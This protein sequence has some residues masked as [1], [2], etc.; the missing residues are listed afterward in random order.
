MFHLTHERPIRT[1][2]RLSAA[3][4]AGCGL[5]LALAACSS[6]GSSGSSTSA[7]STDPDT[8]SSGTAT[9]STAASS[10]SYS[11]GYISDLTGNNGFDLPFEGAFEGAVKAVNA[12]GGIKGRTLNLV[13]C[14]A[15]SNEN[16]AAAC[17]QQ[18][19]SQHVIAVINQSYESTMIPYLQTADI[20]F[21][22]VYGDPSV[23][24][25]PVAFIMNDLNL[26]TTVGME[27]LAKQ[28]GC[29][30]VA[31]IGIQASAQLTEQDNTLFAQGAKTFSIPF[32]G[33][34]TAPMTA[35]AMS[36]YVTQAVATGAQCLI[37]NVNGAQ[38]LSVLQAVISA[39]QI[40][41]LVTG[42]SYL[43]EAGQPQA[44]DPLFKQ[45]GSRAVL[46]LAAEGADDTKN[47]AVAQWVSDQ[48]KYGPAQKNLESISEAAWTEL[49]LVVKAATD[50]YP[51]VTGASI[52]KD[53]DG[54][55]SYWPGV[56]PAISFANPP[57][58]PYGTRVF[59]AWN[60]PSDWTGGSVFPRTGPFVSALTG[61]SCNNTGPT[62]P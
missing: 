54:M 1:K 48:T 33:Q 10:S 2:T 18:M 37:A 29:A 26:A 15:Q 24:N 51:N 53:I 14:D 47:A 60:G 36:P 45:L 49:Q 58:N 6:P 40:K 59:G 13:T 50:V 44:A 52:I 43:S 46:L 56:T 21:F 22:T 41:K 38:L 57:K 32:K 5:A 17:G 34:I 28:A 61:Q 19:A 11:I 55:K 3:V 9:S 7:G 16:A 42:V 30:S 27:G 39:P 31:A 62:C 8:G 23:T 4:V 35:A 25:S 20:P 12:R